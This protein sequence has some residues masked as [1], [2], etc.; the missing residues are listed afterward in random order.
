MQK[1][2]KLID[3]EIRNLENDPFKNRLKIADAEGRK[4]ALKT[5]IQNNIDYTNSLK[6]QL[7]QTELIIEAKDSDI[8]TDIEGKKTKKELKTE[9]DKL[10]KSISEQ[11][12]LLHQIQQIENQRNLRGVDIEAEN[13]FKEELDKAILTGE[14]EVE[15]FERILEMKSEIQKDY[16]KDNL[17]FT[18]E[19]LNEEFNIRKN[20]LIQDLEEERIELL[21][22][23]DLT[24][25]KKL[26]IE[27]NYKKK[28]EELDQNLLIEYTDLQTKIKVE[29]EKSAEELL[30]IEAE[31]NNKIN[32][33]NDEINDALEGRADNQNNSAKDLRNKDLEDQKNYFDQINQLA[34]LSSDF[35]IKQSD[36]KIKRIEAEKNALEKQSDFL[37]ELAVEGNISAKE[38][39]ALNEKL[40]IESNQKKEKELRKQEK[41]KVA[42]SVFD[43]YSR[44]STDPKV[45]NPAV[46][47]IS[48]ISVLTAF[49]NSLPTFY[50]G[51][52]TTVAEALGKPNLSG[53]DGHIV[54]VDGSEKV[55]N[56]K[57][58]KMT[59][60]LT[61][62]EILLYHYTIYL[63]L[64]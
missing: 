33:Y 38:S 62:N 25:E 9:Y 5:A 16:L 40:Q 26:Q 42:M 19:N 3:A 48:D 55:L 36:R 52:E 31:K 22:Q 10:N 34:K 54:R 32:E 46:K 15:N 56:P 43:A 13:K 37:K 64:T 1:Q 58:S 8:D 35:F 44:N 59:G 57:L 18:I 60:N 11:K 61:T 47:T 51:T 2:I 39:L 14:V 30:T 45:K 12:N 28:K 29:T 4:Q 21:K 24:E 23:K 41:I 20:K 63:L 50:E 53:K 17:T 49:I 6:E 7:Y 27:L